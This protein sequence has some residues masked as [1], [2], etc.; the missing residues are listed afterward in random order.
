[1]DLLSLGYTSFFA[2]YR[3]AE[4]QP[5]WIPARITSVHRESYTLHTGDAEIS[6]EL[7]GKFLF[8]AESPGD[9]PCT[10]DWV[11]IQRLDEGQFAVIHTLIPR[12]TVLKR[13]TPGKQV[14]YQMIAANI[15]EAMII[16]SLDADY[17]L[18]RLDRYLVMVEE[19]GIEPAVLLSKSD[20]MEPD[21]VREAGKRIKDI[22]SGLAVIPFSNETGEGLA[23]VRERLKPGKTCCLLG[24][25]GVGKT[26]LLNRLI[27]EEKFETSEVREKDSKGRHTT[28]ARQLII[29]EGGSMIIDT[30]GMRE[31]GTLNAET[32]FDSVFQDIEDL[33]TDCRYADCTHTHEKGCAVSEAV[34]KGMIPRKR[35]ENF[36]RM[37]REAAHY[38]RS[39]LEKR[40]RDK[41]FGKMVKAVKEEKDK[42]RI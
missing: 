35:Y 18:N 1:M 16:Q 29:L 25:S 19:G 30:P 39:Y 34:A 13:K 38:S 20:L 21:Q 31:L 27:G 36:L 33:A 28:S 41:S 22:H 24:S 8:T 26:T 40:Q 3:P 7:T 14:D 37:Q 17:S 5:D 32:G 10:G 23:A 12:K 11:A 15:D 4:M 9:Y 6:A 42:R 2:D